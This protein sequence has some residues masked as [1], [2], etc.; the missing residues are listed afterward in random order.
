MPLQNLKVCMQHEPLRLAVGSR[1]SLRSTVSCKYA[2]NMQPAVA[3][4]CTFHVPQC[5]AV[6]KAGC[7]E[8]LFSALFMFPDVFKDACGVLHPRWFNII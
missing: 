6:P 7:W 8:P 1:C 4:P 3:A 5:S 2:V